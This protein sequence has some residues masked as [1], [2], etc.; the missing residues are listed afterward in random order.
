MACWGGPY[1]ISP[2]TCWASEGKWLVKS[3][4]EKLD[5]SLIHI[6]K[7][8]VMK[9]GEWKKHEKKTKLYSNDEKRGMENMKLLLKWWKRVI[10][11][12]QKETKPCN[13]WK[14]TENM[15]T[16]EVKFCSSNEKRGMENMKKAS[17]TMF[18]WWKKGNGKHENNR[19]KTLCKC[20]FCT[21]Y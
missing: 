4:G 15:K 10:G 7:L 11:N 16:T 3:W 8:E 9:K 20:P 13:W 1:A 19:N 5:L 6:S 21:N 18:K 2:T 14:K 17:K 12:I